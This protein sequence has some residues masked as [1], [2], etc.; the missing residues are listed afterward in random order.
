MNK[1]SIDQIKKLREET[2]AGVMEIKRALEEASGDAQKAKETLRK[3]GLV[4]ADKK[5]GRATQ[6]GIVEAY[7]HATKTGGATVVLTCETDFVARTEEFQN[8]AHELAMQIC[9]MNPRSVEELLVQ[10]WIRDESRTIEDLIKEHIGRFGENIKVQEFKRFE[11]G[12][13]RT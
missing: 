9:A 13:V 3:Y 11:V 10:P 2:G 7:I 8:L 5:A 12:K 1:I 4:K 6:A